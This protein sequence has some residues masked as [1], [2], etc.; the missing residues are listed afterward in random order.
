MPSFPWTRTI[1]FSTGIYGIYVSNLSDQSASLLISH[2]T[3]PIHTKTIDIPANQDVLQYI[4]GDSQ[5]I[6]L[7]LD[8]SSENSNVYIQVSKIQEVS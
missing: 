7:S 3:K 5:N 6:Q 8:S 1:S 4:D 2:P